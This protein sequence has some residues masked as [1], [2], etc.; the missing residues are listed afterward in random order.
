MS[1]PE[2]KL[3][4]YAVRTRRMDALGSEASCKEACIAISRPD[5]EAPEIGVANAR[6]KA[7]ARTLRKNRR[8][9]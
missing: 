5:R 4:T 7:W 3:L 9:G 2:A 8:H 6:E 1:N